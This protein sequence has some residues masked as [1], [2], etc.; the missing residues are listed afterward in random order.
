MM[1]IQGATKNIAAAYHKLDQ[2]GTL[3][4]GKFADL[5]VVDA[6][7]LQDIQNMRKL[8][9]VMK[10]GKVIDVNALPLYPIL[11]SPEAMNP[12]VVRTK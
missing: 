12:G 9:V 5:V 4:P 1:I 3:D 8:S 10:E 11:T 6:D 7:P 2:L